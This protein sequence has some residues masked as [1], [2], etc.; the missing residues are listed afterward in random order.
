M[1]TYD[2]LGRIRFVLKIIIGDIS[3]GWISGKRVTIDESMIKYCGRM[4]SFVQSLPEKPI[5]YGMKV[6][7]LCCEYTGYLLGFEVY[8]GKDTDT[9]EDSA[10]KIVDKLITEASLVGERGRILYIDN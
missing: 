7:A 8:L 3:A 1:S 2:P 10:L 6:F 9:E 4:I 5:K